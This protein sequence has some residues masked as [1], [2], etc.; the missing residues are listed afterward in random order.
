MQGWG[1]GKG[2]TV[3]P[4]VTPEHW[5][6]LGTVLCQW[7]HSII[8]FKETVFNP[9]RSHFLIALLHRYECKISK[10]LNV[11]LFQSETM[12]EFLLLFID[13]VEE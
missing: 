3:P 12:G 1:G 13:V 4:A 10:R 7:A 11:V 5:I 2:D 8:Q 6:P 9:M